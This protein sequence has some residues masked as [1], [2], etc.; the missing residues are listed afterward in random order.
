AKQ[1]SPPGDQHRC[2]ISW[3]TFPND[4]T[5]TPDLLRKV[6]EKLRASLL[7]LNSISELFQKTLICWNGS[8]ALDQDREVDRGAAV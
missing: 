3:I 6:P 2:W 5:L 1:Q 4:A 8:A 7:L